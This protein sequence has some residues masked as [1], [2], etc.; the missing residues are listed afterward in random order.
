MHYKALLF[1]ILFVTS[2][3]RIANSGEDSKQVDAKTGQW[4]TYYYRQPA[5]EYFVAGVRELAAAGVLDQKSMNGVILGFTTEVMRQNPDRVSTWLGELDDL[6]ETGRKLLE[7]AAWRSQT[8]EALAVLT[9]RGIDTKKLPKPASPSDEPIDDP[10]KLD[11]M[12]GT[13]LAS[14]DA[15]PVRRVIET[16]EYTND[17]EAIERY[18]RTH[19]K[20]DREAVKRYIMGQAALWSLKSN[21]EQHPR[22]LEICEVVAKEKSLPRHADLLLVKLLSEIKPEEYGFIVT[23]AASED[24]Q[25]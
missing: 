4:M 20:E 1:S 19:S 8:K 12:W 17:P 3:T 2:L 7:L 5:P 9:A 15:T 10:G 23:D 22:V 16:L 21:A 6:S 24:A 13:F 14:G 25:Q 11:L 18:R